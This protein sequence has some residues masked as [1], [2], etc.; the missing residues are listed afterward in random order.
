ML[1]PSSSCCDSATITAETVWTFHS[2]LVR[3]EVLEV[4][5][6]S[7]R[8]LVP[9]ALPKWSALVLNN[10]LLYHGF[11]TNTWAYKRKRSYI[12]GLIKYD[13]LNYRN[14]TP[15]TLIVNEYMSFPSREL[16]TFCRW[17]QW[18]LVTQIGK[19]AYSQL[20]LETI[21]KHSD[22][23]WLFLNVH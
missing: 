3:M 11:N 15:L 14:Y 13:S 21:Y 16:L 19:V 23:P 9:H 5:I 17:T 22:H 8:K 6:P 12:W 1:M 10:V 2:F 4:A 20:P 7:T 18:Q